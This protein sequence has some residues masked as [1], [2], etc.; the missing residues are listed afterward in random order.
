MVSKI[1]MDAAALERRDRLRKLEQRHIELGRLLQG[2]MGLDPDDI[3]T[4]PRPQ[5]LENVNTRAQEHEDDD[6]NSQMA[7]ALEDHSRPP[8]GVASSR[9]SSVS[10]SQ[11]G[12]GA[13]SPLLASSA[14]PPPPPPL[15]QLEIERR[16]T[17]HD[18]ILASQERPWREWMQPAD[19][20]ELTVEEQESIVRNHPLFT[21]ALSA[22]DA[23]EQRLQAALASNIALN[24]KVEALA[25]N[26][27]KVLK[28][29][30]LFEDELKKAGVPLKP[31]HESIRREREH[32]MNSTISH[33]R[34]NRTE[35]SGI[36][37]AAQKGT[38][39]LQL[40]ADGSAVTIDRLKSTLEARDEE[41][42]KAY[43]E[44][45]RL[46]SL[47][48]KFN[49]K[50]QHTDP[51]NLTDGGYDAAVALSARKVKLDSVLVDLRVNV[52]ELE[53]KLRG[54]EQRSER[55]AVE[56]SASADCLEQMERRLTVSEQE[57]TQARLEVA[58]LRSAVATTDEDLPLL[59]INL[60]DID[61]LSIPLSVRKVVAKCH[62]QA[63][64]LAEQLNHVTEDF[65][66][67]LGLHSTLSADLKKRVETLEAENIA[68]RNALH[69]S[70]S[71]T[72]D[73][74]KKLAQATSTLEQL[75]QSAILASGVIGTSRHDINRII[76]SLEIRHSSSAPNDV[77][78]ADLI[79]DVR[80]F[81]HQVARDL[82]LISELLAEMRKLRSDGVLDAIS[83]TQ[84][85]F[86][87]V[88]QPA[89]DPP[90]RASTIRPT[91]A[92]II[93][94]PAPIEALKPPSAVNRLEGPR[95]ESSSSTWR[96]PPVASASPSPDPSPTLER[97]K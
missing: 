59:D 89:V 7:D 83:R 94:P 30:N 35:S 61:P 27:V 13:K 75:S 25:R 38:S 22:A 88:T 60:E 20:R 43:Q 18:E 66:M 3:I 80:S 12:K 51:S 44:L 34:D 26:L 52:Q 36:L 32:S 97:Y 8:P 72:D 90:L 56:L 37:V 4:A 68:L 54:A 67:Q 2:A 84:G 31:V 41:L 42:R 91:R 78:D 58:Q 50:A 11:K 69:D 86:V 45:E 76:R 10:G 93:S 87:E 73:T 70:T 79:G 71:H 46:T 57:V 33:S 6:L 16:P 53:W 92:V 55:L 29:R 64:V 28:E 48:V 9:T 24:K 40:N 5:S 49:V 81:A 74:T 23:S 65:R 62:A 77:M 17:P 96:A 95:S 63:T 82:S 39:P 85:R 15:A 14:P 19:P 1:D 47:G 21:E